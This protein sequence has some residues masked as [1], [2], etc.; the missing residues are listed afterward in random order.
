ML[1]K[2]LGVAE[3]D[4]VDNN[5]E[6]LAIAQKLKANNI[7]SS[8]HQVKSK[9][10]LVIDTSSTNNGLATAM[11]SVRNFGTLSSSGIY[12]KKTP[13]SLIEM[14]AKGVNFKIGFA[15]ARTDAAQILKLMEKVVIP[16]ELA[17][18]KIDSWENAEN[19]FLTETTKVIVKREQLKLTV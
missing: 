18:T 9:Y 13:L 12:I 1:A 5:Q 15:N 14:Y 19:A 3:V 2:A 16:F 8:Y 4:Y 17:T 11:K 7:Y 6:R 10:D